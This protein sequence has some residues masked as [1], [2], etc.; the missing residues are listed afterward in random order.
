MDAALF[1]RVMAIFGEA[2]GLAGPARE[3]FL[4]QQ[5]TG[6]PALRGQVDKLLAQHSHFDSSS[7]A[8]W[9]P[10]AGA[11]WLA[12]AIVKVDDEPMKP[13]HTP[14]AGP[15]RVLA[16]D[17]RIIRVLG[18]GGMGVV[19][20]A[21]QLRPRRT[22]ALK[23][24]RSGL[25]SRQALKRFEHE[26]NVLG[27]LQHPGIAQIYEAGAADRTLADQAFFVME[28]VRGLP[29]HKHVELHRLGV[30]DR[31]RLV[32][33]ICD[34]VQHAHQRGVIHRDLKPSNILVDE[35]GQPKIL[36]FGVARLTDADSAHTTFHTL[37]GQLIGTLAYMSPE[38]VTGD[39][40]D[41]DT[42]CDIYAMGVILRQLLTGRL[43][44]DFG[45]R[46]IHEAARMIIEV[47]PPRLGAVDPSYRGDLDVIVGKAMDKD[48]SRR[49]Q[50]A[51][52]LAADLQRFL[53]GDPIAA[54]QDSQLYVIGK[55]VRRH[56]HPI[57]AAAIVMAALA[58]FG[59]YAAV[60]AKRNLELANRE[61][62]AK[63]QAQTAL[64]R[65]TEQESIASDRARQLER[66]LYFN[67][68]GFAH[69]AHLA[70]DSARMRQLLDECPPLMRGWE[71][72]Y[73]DSINDL[74]SQSIHVQD[75]GH[76]GGH[77]SERG[78]RLVSWDHLSGLRV[79]ET[80]D[81]TKVVLEFIGN[82]M[83]GALNPD[84][85][86]MV[87]LRADMPA[88][89]HWLDG[90]RQPMTL[91]GTVQHA[92][93]PAFSHDGQRLFLGLKP[94]SCIIDATSGATLVDVDTKNYA[95]LSAAFTPDGDH[96]VMSI[97]NHLALWNSR[98]GKRLAD[99]K[100]HEQSVR[101]I[102]I[103]PDGTQ[104]A[105]AGFDS[106][107][108]LWDLKTQR[109]L[110][111]YRPHDNKIQAV[112]FSP[113]GKFVATGS[114]DRTICITRIADGAIDRQL[115]GHENTV[116]HVSFDGS[117]ERLFSLSRDGTLKSW[118]VHSPRT[119]PVINVTGRNL[120]GVAM[121]GDGRHLLTPAYSG[122]LFMVEAR[123]GEVVR[124]WM[125]HHGGAFDIRSSSDGSWIA[126]CGADGAVRLWNAS[127]LDQP[128]VA[129]I[130]PDAGALH[131]LSFDP[132]N[133]MIA[134]AGDRG[135][136]WIWQI[137]S[138]SLWRAIDAT[139][140]PLYALAWDKNQRLYATG[141]QAV[142]YVVKPTGDNTA[143]TI[144][145]KLNTPL[146]DLVV[147]P[148][149]N[150]MVTCGEDGVTRMWDAPSFSQQRA[151][152]GHGGAVFC[153]VFHP[154]GSRLVTGSYDNLIKVWD[155]DSGDEILTLRG[156]TFS[157]TGLAF[158]PDGRWLASCNDDGTIR[159]WG[160]V[161][162]AQ[163]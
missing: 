97:D 141:E 51:A 20:E 117:G 6:D 102:D 110:A 5:C 89:L 87:L 138:R 91:E 158:S 54:R 17:Y 50:S 114:T 98:T 109:Q 70:N 15:V 33:K 13:P 19:Y 140:R 156:H 111:V 139:D 93:P 161:R 26:A 145:L 76:V 53:D 24:L 21:E 73:L 127:D 4:D 3:Q 131:T 65:A 146:W 8:L 35:T 152:P 135:S 99:W 128:P 58:T 10:G 104:I 83:S 69:A 137:Q 34:A 79:R 2:C 39:A 47:D 25:T 41:I 150:T 49:Y 59:I 61:G 149:G 116:T 56:R 120:R 132:S 71:W 74:S 136:I 108:R 107:L 46:P 151:C 40:T 115:S 29:L 18:E 92:G 82:A 75:F 126:T 142:V 133:Q 105:S 64:Q 11:Q 43:P 112:A 32:I 85:S 160:D 100:A 101:A 60:Q 63:S 154:D 162:P 68:I 27:K 143:T 66:T 122:E 155:V 28:L 31:V 67:R 96:L 153:A 148:D 22:V 163:E 16:G 81:L 119:R 88:T 36:D 62:H 94:K 86:C 125:A 37:E 134:A 30:V 7:E 23:A 1:Q 72:N 147:S 80:T 42:R 129:L 103:S 90:S 38:Q 55:L 45:S 159:I 124:T 9:N 78:N 130:V 106:S 118:D 77:L 144:D 48:K 52:E 57:M 84:G 113:C 157:T 123:R 14:R 121:V 12:D 95:M 44:F